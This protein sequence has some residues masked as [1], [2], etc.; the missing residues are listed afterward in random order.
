MSENHIDILIGKALSGNATPG[1]LAELK[2]LKKQS[3]EY[4]EAYTQSQKIWQHAESWIS[5]GDI[6]QDKIKTQ[7]EINKNLFRQIR[8]SKRLLSIYKL[9]AILAFPIALAISLLLMKQNQEDVLLV[10]TTTEITA[11]TGHIAKCKL[12][13]GTEVWINSGSTITYDAS[14]FGSDTREV[15][16]NGEAY[17]E[18]FKDRQ[19]TFFVRT[20]L[21]DVKVTGTSFNVKAHSDSQSFETVLSEGS[22]ELDLKRQ[23]QELLKMEPGERVIYEKAQGKVLVQQVD[24]ELFS[25]W[26]NGEIIFKDATLNDL[27]NELERIYGVRFRF[28]DPNMA[29]YRFRGMFSYSNNLIDAL[30]KIKVT[31]QVDYYIENKEVWLKKRN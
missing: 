27:A 25:S 26:R 17:F 11:P 9:A 22:V 5:K 8:R 4:T 28:E 31:A 1:E 3:Q 15:S 16:L 10:S 21:A 19:K 7:G 30:E 24:P 13:D 6:Q 29:G 18:V 20:P 2:E 14:G 23:G 12:P